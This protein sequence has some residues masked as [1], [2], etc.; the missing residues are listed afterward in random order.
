MN[1]LAAIIK[2]AR[3]DVQERE[4][5][6]ASAKARAAAALADVAEEEGGLSEARTALGWLERYSVSEP[7]AASPAEQNGGQSQPKMRFGKPVP[8]G[9]SKLQLIMD[10]LMD[11][12]GI[13]SNKQISTR[14]LRDGV[15][16]K[17]EHVRGL[18]KYEGDKPHPQ[19]VTEPGSG[20]WRLN[21]A[22][23]AS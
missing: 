20:V 7:V 12:G 10:A 2:Q 21:N 6:V 14:L 4:A 17:P 9:P 13:A 1:D 23:S 5:R 18:L 22:G 11:L 3:A 16:I 8:E 15:D 19:V